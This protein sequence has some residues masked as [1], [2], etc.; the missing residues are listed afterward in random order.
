[1]EK[2]IIGLLFFFVF[3]SCTSADGSFIVTPFPHTHAHT[4][5]IDSYH[6]TKLTIRIWDMSKWISI[7]A[8]VYNTHQPYK[9]W[10]HI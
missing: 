6:V 4:E 2:K 3:I 5:S 10:G 8:C 1:M 9:N 7:Y